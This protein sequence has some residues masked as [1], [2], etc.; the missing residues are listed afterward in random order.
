MGPA[1]PPS[2]GRSERSSAGCPRPIPCGAR[3]GFMGSSGSSVSRSP[4]PRSRSTCSA[5][6]CR[7][8]RPGARSWPTR[9]GR[10]SP[11]TSSS[12]PRWCSGCC[13]S[14]SSWRTTGDASSERLIR[15]LRR[16]CL[17][18]VV[19]LN[20]THLRR[21]LH[22]YLAYYHG[23]RTH[24]S[25]DKDVPGA[26]TGGASRPESDRRDA[27]D[28][29]PPSSVHSPGSISSGRPPG[30]PGHA[31]VG[32]RS[33]GAVSLGPALPYDSHGNPVV[34]PGW[35]PAARAFEEGSQLTLRASGWAKWKGQ[36]DPADAGGRA[37]E[38]ARSPSGL[39]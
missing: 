28:R 10:S 9:R 4:R 27:P 18:H 30:C 2:R 38:P 26:T 24:L 15:T 23:A 8:H 12:C 35:Y 31:D 14:S 11:W 29:R 39:A 6:G 7:H 37:A 3:R 34:H 22:A 32:G 20:E 1:A 21:L 25:L 13:S 5:A 36:P 19:A 33:V 16:E 17:H